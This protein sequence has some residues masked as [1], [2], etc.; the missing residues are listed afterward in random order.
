MVA[1]AGFFGRLYIQ[2]II[3]IVIGAVF[4]YPLNFIFMISDMDLRIMVSSLF[5]MGFAAGI[6]FLR[7][8]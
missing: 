5:L 8:M 3:L 4:A 1:F 2:L 7:K 6:M